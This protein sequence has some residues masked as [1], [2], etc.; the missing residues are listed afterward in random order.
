MKLR[1]IGI[2]LLVWMVSLCAREP[3][4]PLPQI[5]K[6]DKAK[7]ELG[8]QLFEDPLLSSDKT[9]SC[10]TC[11]SFA[12]GGADP[13]P[14]SIGVEGQKGNIQSPTVYNCPFQF[15]TVL[16]RPGGFA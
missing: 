1:A 6:Y 7:A 5:V 13:R 9:V 10:S 16:E 8:R 14:V 3:I 12:Y 15:Q 4:V 11:H 2:S